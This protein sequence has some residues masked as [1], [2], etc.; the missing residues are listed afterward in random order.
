MAV[1]NLNWE[2]ETKFTRK[3]VIAMA[4]VA[5]FVGNIEK[6]LSKG[7]PSKFKDFDWVSVLE[8]MTLFSQLGIKD[9]IAY[10]AICGAA[11]DV[12]AGRVQILFGKP[13]VVSSE[14]DGDLVMSG[15]IERVGEC[16]ITVPMPEKPQIRWF[17]ESEQAFQPD[18]ET[19]TTKDPETLCD[20]VS[21]LLKVLACVRSV[22]STFM[23][24]SEKWSLAIEICNEINDAI[25]MLYLIPEASND[26][27]TCVTDCH[28][29]TSVGTSSCNETQC[30]RH[31]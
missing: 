26:P 3:Q 10:K 23:V 11:A 2:L 21:T 22:K 25:Q 9:T 14:E 5:E 27:M 24:G 19:Q 29:I 15:L 20:S 8:V 7:F 6:D 16:V 28:K 30:S 12:N 1:K 4:K 31:T 17:R 18:V 13:V